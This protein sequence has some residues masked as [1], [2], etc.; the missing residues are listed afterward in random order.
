MVAVGRIP[1]TRLFGDLERHPD[2]VRVPGIFVF[3]IEAPLIFANAESF[4]TSFADALGREMRPI[5]L[6]IIDLQRSPITDYTAAEM[7]RN[8]AT[9]LERKGVALRLANTSGQVRDLMRAAEVEEMV[10]R[11]D[12]T[13]TIDALCQQYEDVLDRD[14]GSIG[15]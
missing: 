10:G 9:E 11:L 5:H 6:A 7:I 3:R 4:R 2:N 12:R 15:P 13:T 8:L 14:D 1:G